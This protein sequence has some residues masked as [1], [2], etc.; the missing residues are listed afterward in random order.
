MKRYEIL[1]FFSQ[2][3]NALCFIFILIIIIIIIN[4][5]EAN[6]ERGINNKLENMHI[7]QK[8]FKT[9]GSAVKRTS[10]IRLTFNVFSST[11]CIEIHFNK[12]DDGTWLVQS[13]NINHIFKEN[14]INKRATNVYFSKRKFLRRLPSSRVIYAFIWLWKCK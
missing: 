1:N 12:G 10:L 7:M 6:A 9:R 13:R 4:L 14:K 5:P 2:K 8:V 11:L 3:F